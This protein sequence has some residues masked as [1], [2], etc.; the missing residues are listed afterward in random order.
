MVGRSRH[1]QAGP[2]PGAPPCLEIVGWKIGTFAYGFYIESSRSII[3][4]WDIFS[5]K[6]RFYVCFGLF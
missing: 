3:N 1:V 6:I 2:G 5:G 4:F